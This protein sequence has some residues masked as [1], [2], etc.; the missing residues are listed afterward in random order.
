MIIARPHD[1]ERLREAERLP[2]AIFNHPVVQTALT[3]A[4]FCHRSVGGRVGNQQKVTLN[5]FSRF[6]KLLKSDSTPFLLACL[7]ERLFVEVRRSAL[8]A[9]RNAFIQQY[10]NLPLAVLSQMIGCDSDE[11]CEVVCASF[12]ILV[13]SD[14][15]RSVE[16]H[17]GMALTSMYIFQTHGEARH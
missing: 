5:A 2:K 16:L 13:G 9:I 3:L 7:A 14:P 4:N 10:Q 1:W 8:S 17:K 6:F 12:N 11:N 15:D